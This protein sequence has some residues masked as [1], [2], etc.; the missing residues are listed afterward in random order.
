MLYKDFPR[1]ADFQYRTTGECVVIAI[2]SMPF[3]NNFA[4]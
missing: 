1:K 4:T 2:L 3:L